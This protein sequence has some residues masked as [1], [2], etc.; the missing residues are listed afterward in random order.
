MHYFL[1]FFKFWVDC[2]VCRQC[3]DRSFLRLTWNVIKPLMIN[4]FRVK[5]IQDGIV[6]HV[7]KRSGR[8]WASESIDQM[9][10]KAFVHHEFP[11]ASWI[12]IALPNIGR[13][14]AAMVGARTLISRHYLT[15][16]TSVWKK[17]RAWAGVCLSQSPR[18]ISAQRSVTP[19]RGN[20]I[21]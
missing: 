19:H 15:E 11:I 10:S 2:I 17:L 13:L 12:W 5:I 9:A 18:L 3:L 4:M 8:W 14:S 20:I 6:G 16:P 1:F 7:C 21:A